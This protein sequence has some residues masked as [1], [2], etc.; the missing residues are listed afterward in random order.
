MAFIRFN[1]LKQNRCGCQIY[2]NNI[3]SRNILVCS[4]STSLPTGLG[5]GPAWLVCQRWYSA[6]AMHSSDLSMEQVPSTLEFE[7]MQVRLTMVWIR[8]CTTGQFGVIDRQVSTRAKSLR[9]KKNKSLNIP[10]V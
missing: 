2:F 5:G 7:C 10:V 6:E 3:I 1:G 8:F 4:F 9:I